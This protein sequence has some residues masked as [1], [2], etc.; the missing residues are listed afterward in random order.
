ML[1]RDKT[2]SERVNTDTSSIVLCLLFFSYVC[3]ARS[4]PVVLINELSSF[5]NL[6]S[7]FIGLIVSITFIPYVIM[8]VPFGVIV[9]RFGIRTLVSL[10]C[11]ICSIGVFIFGVA[12]SVFQ[13]E[14]GRFLLGL[15]SASAYVCCGK[16]A[17]DSFGRKGYSII[18][19]IATA[20]GCLGSMVGVTPVACLSN[21]I[22]WRNAM[23]V[24]AVIGGI[25]ACSALVFIPKK[26]KCLNI[27]KEDQ[28]P[29]LEG[30]KT[31]VSN[32][33][34]WLL[35]FCGAIL[36]L[37]ESALAELWIVPFAEIRYGISTKLASISSL[38]MFVGVA[39][40]GVLVTWFAELINSRKK[41]MMTS[42]ILLVAVLWVSLYCDIR[43]GLFL[44]FLMLCGVLSAASILS[45]AIAFRAFP[46]SKYGGV[47]TGVLNALVM[48]SGMIFQ[49]LMGKALDF[50]RN[51]M[52]TELG[53]PVY[54][55]TAYRSSF[56]ICIIC[57]V[58]ASIG[59]FFIDES[60]SFSK[61]R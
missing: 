30:L 24:M 25:I 8:Q 55:L 14:F 39:L 41:V 5:F 44:I 51:G 34:I 7:S 17:S 6:N 27:E 20:V 13:L 16:V 36:Y 59:V 18:M 32:P 52:V 2:N 60:E 1:F 57:S 37:P 38:S 48:S 28:T 33:K 42:S 10:C 4:A 23:L 9:D 54:S 15:F 40:G 22:G 56:L 29:T 11:A 19:G 50:F 31:I 53:I 43:Y 46:N 12:T 3:A 45:Y 35:G 49:P 26:S 61:K 58:L 21:S 47:L